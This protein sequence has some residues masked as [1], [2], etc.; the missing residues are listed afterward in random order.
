M[1]NSIVLKNGAII[2]ITPDEY[3]AINTS[4]LANSLFINLPRMQKTFS[5]STIAEVGVPNLMLNPKVIGAEFKFE[6]QAVIALIEG[7]QQLAYRGEQWL[8]C[9]Q[10]TYEAAMTFDE[11]IA[12]NTV[13]I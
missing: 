5:T 1:Q 13:T 4:L 12:A 6:Q 2:W 3:A 7:G 9:K 11:L 10:G 8:I